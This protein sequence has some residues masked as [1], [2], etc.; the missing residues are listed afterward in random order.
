MRAPRFVFLDPDGT[1][2]GRWL[3][4]VVEA[5]TGVFYQQQYGGAACRQG[6]V[7]GF[8]VP[9]YDL[10]A[11]DALRDLFE[12]DF[13][14]AGTWNH[15]WP[16]DER[17]RL[18]DIV[19]SIPYWTCDGNADRRHDLRLD[20]SRIREVDEAWVPVATPDGPGVLMWRNSD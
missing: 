15:P 4:V 10:A 16:D 12:K 9:V 20:E 11:L 1:S 19:G 17:N 14:R 2:G 6:H 7:E 5:A 3:Y 13:R 8:L 18:R